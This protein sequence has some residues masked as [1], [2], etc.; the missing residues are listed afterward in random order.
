MRIKGMRGEAEAIRKQVAKQAAVWT[1][2]QHDLVG[3]K[4]VPE[5]KGKRQQVR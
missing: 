5:S 2:L 3:L 4:A 1:N